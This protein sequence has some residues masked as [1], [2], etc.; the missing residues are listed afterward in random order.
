MWQAL[1]SM[2]SVFYLVGDRLETG[3]SEECS[4]A[5]D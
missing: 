2:E 3:R 1:L 4:G 5:H